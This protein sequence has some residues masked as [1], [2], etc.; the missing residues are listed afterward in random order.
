MQV[1]QLEMCLEL[2]F[3][4]RSRHVE[5]FCFGQLNARL[6]IRLDY[7]PGHAARFS[8]GPMPW[9]AALLVASSAR[10]FPL[11]KIQG[12]RSTHANVVSRLDLAARNVRHFQPMIGS[13]WPLSFSVELALRGGVLGI[14]HCDYLDISWRQNGVWFQ[15]TSTRQLDSRTWDGRAGRTY[16]VNCPGLAPLLLPDILYPHTNDGAS[17]TMQGTGMV[18]AAPSLRRRRAAANAR[19]VDTALLRAAVRPLQRGT[20]H[21]HGLLHGRT[22][23]SKHNNLGIKAGN[24]ASL[25]TDGCERSAIQSLP[26]GRAFIQR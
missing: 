15:L 25:L 20:R 24:A 8:T 13:T 12:C 5:V 19:L 2:A 4:L 9:L 16:N 1:A 17:F 18:Q 6:H 14:P 10:P 7:D 21:D 3:R 22:L 11:L 23:K 26:A